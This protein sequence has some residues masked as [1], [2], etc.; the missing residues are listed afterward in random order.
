MTALLLRLGLPPDYVQALSAAAASARAGVPLAGPAWFYPGGGWVAPAAWVRHALSTAG[1]TFVGGVDVQRVA[2]AT[3]GQWQLHDIHGRLQAQAPIVVLA[4]AASAGLLLTRAGHA[5]WPLHHTRGQVTQWT[6]PHALQL[7][8][9][10]DGYAIPLSNG[11]LCGA[12]REVA[13]PG[14]KA[15]QPHDHPHNLQ[16]LQS[17]CGL[18]PPAGAAL[19]G[20]TGW[21]LH[22]DD[23]LPIAGALP[24][25]QMPA[26]QRMDQARLLPREPGLFVLTALGARGLTLAPLLGRLVAAQA[27]GTPWP[28]EQ[29]LADAVDPGRW[30]VRAARAPLNRD[31]RITTRRSQSANQLPPG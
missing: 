14:D 31:E 10:G 11:L 18:R 13:E 7:P 15:A 28:L 26:G 24:C 22:A 21:R 12:T 8:I 9:A 4:N 27:T 16:R 1:V 23:R 20:R 17:L 30:Q 6:G 25:L 2:R 3:D 19:Q 29:D 5:G